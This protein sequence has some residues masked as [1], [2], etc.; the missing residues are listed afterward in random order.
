[1]EQF[2]RNTTPSR[3]VAEIT[4]DNLIESFENGRIHETDPAFAHLYSNWHKDL[5]RVQ[6]LKEK[7]D[8]EENGQLPFGKL[9]E[10]LIYRELGEHPLAQTLTFRG[11]SLYD[12]YFNGVDVV[13]EPKSGQVQALATLDITINQQDIR[14]TAYRNTEGAAARPVGLVQK[15]IRSKK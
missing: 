15:L 3:N 1:M 4:P 5:N 13:V 8:Q 2:N 11:S 14:G 10:A 12:D 6:N 9:A 7:F